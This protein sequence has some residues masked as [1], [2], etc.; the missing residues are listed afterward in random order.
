MNTTLNTLR[1]MDPA[2]RFEDHHAASQASR[3][4]LLMAILADTPTKRSRR[5]PS[6]LAMLVPLAAVA[7][8][9]AL[10]LPNL[11]RGAPTSRPMALGA[12]SLSVEE[13]RSWNEPVA[14]VDPD[15]PVAAACAEQLVANPGADSSTT[16]INGDTRGLVS[17]VIVSS[18]EYAAWCVGSDSAPMYL[19]LDGPDYEPASPAA[20]SVTL[21]PSGARLPPNG[22]GFAAGRT[23]DD[24]I[25]V[26]LHEDGLTIE[27]TV[28]NGWWTAWWPS[29]DE[30]A[31]ITGT[32]DITD[33][34][35]RVNSV[36]ADSVRPLEPT[37]P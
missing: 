8:V 23:G 13:L 28:A 11:L 4:H 6:V 33:K 21:G 29:D 1:S 25:S 16:A 17:S 37:A 19:L 34:S 12:G 2:K 32:L 9:A 3:E 7:A 31:L 26:T 18:G 20:D 24:V 27:A 10:V 14:T 36:S 30:T 15:S 35:G 5:M 22:Y